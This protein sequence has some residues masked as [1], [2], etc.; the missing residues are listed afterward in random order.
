M[1]AILKYKYFE[2]NGKETMLFENAYDENTKPLTLDI[3]KSF[4]VSKPPPSCF[5]V[6]YFE[7]DLSTTDTII[8]PEYV[9]TYCSYSD[10]LKDCV[11]IDL[12]FDDSEIEYSINNKINYHKTIINDKIF[13]EIKIEHFKF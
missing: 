1:E 6:S 9:G 7:V 13:A 10:Y 3:L 2:N 4:R 8:E 5:R 11:V 12:S